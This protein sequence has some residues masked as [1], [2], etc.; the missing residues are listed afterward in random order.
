MNVRRIVSV[1]LSA[2]VVALIAGCTDGGIVTETPSPTRAAPSATSSP[3]P[4]ASLGPLTD[5]EL[6]AM[7]PPDAAFGDV[8]GAIATA[9]FFLEQ[10]AHRCYET[11]DLR[12]WD[13]LSMPDCIFCESVREQRK[14]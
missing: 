13:A 7:M 14:R 8:R 3:A 1:V 5:E 11:G 12:A 2:V 9:K 4:S 6:L 10:Y